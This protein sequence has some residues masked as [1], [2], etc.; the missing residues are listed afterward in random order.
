MLILDNVSL[1]HEK[2]KIL[3]NI[4]LYCMQWMIT[5]LHW[6]N[7]SWKSTILNAII[8]N[9][10]IDWWKIIYWVHSNSWDKN[11]FWYMPQNNLLFEH[12]SCY[13]NIIL[14]IS[15]LDIIWMHSKIK[16]I[17]D[18]FSLNHIL[19][20]Y[21]HQI[22]LWQKQLI[23]FIR[24]ILIDSEYII[25]DE[26]TS[27]LEYKNIEIMK[28]ILLNE[29]EKGKTILIISHDTIF[30]QNIWDK[31]YKINEWKIIKK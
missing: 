17:I 19:N 10:D 25:L 23:S 7:G 21:P 27:A 11:Y 9:H 12:L 5:I 30:S 4:N 1:S 28:E 24:A 18:K 20:N 6:C 29:K 15:D 13:E 14:T 22:S 31:K 26:P 3:T 8:W 16:E 2:N